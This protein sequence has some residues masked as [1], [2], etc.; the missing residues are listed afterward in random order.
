MIPLPNEIDVAP[1]D[2]TAWLMDS[3]LNAV[4]ETFT[5][6]GIDLPALRY[7]TMEE[8]VHDCEQ[9]TVTCL[10]A[11]L[12]PPGEQADTPQPCSG[13]RSAVFQ[14][15]VV[16]CVDDGTPTNLRQRSGSTAP[17][18][19]KASEYAR[20]RTR[21]IWALLWVPNNIPDYNQSIIADVSATEMS[22]K[23]QG[24]VLNLIVQI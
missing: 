4:E 19:E 24:V 10:Q 21:D 7:L 16:R 12:G 9:V 3:I 8:P 15:E 23:F 14:V 20:Q 17:D 2:K 1:I 13:P 22:G 6:F 18:P 5:S 11:Y